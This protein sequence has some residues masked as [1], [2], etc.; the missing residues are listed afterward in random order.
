MPKQEGIIF[1]MIIKTKLNV[2]LISRDKKTSQLGKETFQCRM[3]VSRSTTMHVIYL[4]TVM[5]ENLQHFRQNEIIH[6][7]PSVL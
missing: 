5:Y 4:E 1:R 7:F 6:P 3:L 2:F